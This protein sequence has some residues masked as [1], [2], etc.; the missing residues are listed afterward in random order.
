MV[1]IANLDTLFERIDD[2][3]RP[4]IERGRDLRLVGIVGT[5]RG[6]ERA[7]PYQLGCQEGRPGRR[8]GDDDVALPRYREI[9]ARPHVDLEFP[10]EIARQLFGGVRPDVP[11]MD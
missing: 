4:G 6:N 7:W 1:Q 11:D 10:A 3:L 2:R 9:G 8:R 5:D